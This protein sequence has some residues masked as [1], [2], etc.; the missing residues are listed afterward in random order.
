M[1]GLACTEY[2]T[3]LETQYKTFC[4]AP[5]RHMEDTGCDDYRIIT[6]SSTQLWVLLLARTN[7][8]DMQDG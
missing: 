3:G 5:V 8:P 7:Q 1:Q 6:P 4:E 2:E